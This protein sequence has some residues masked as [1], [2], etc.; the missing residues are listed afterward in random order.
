[1]GRLVDVRDGPVNV[2]QSYDGFRLV[3][4]FSI[5]RVDA[6]LVRPDLTNRGVFDDGW[7]ATQAFW[8]LWATLTVPRLLGGAYYLGHDRQQAAYEQGMGHELRHTIGAR[9][10][11]QAAPPLYLEVEGAYQLGRFLQGDI[12]A[13]MVVFLAVVRVPRL[14]LHPE[15]A[16]GVGA[17]SGD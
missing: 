11:V 10:G 6:F 13:W 8:G 14:A 2:R 16:L 9:V 7:D 12:S 3:S 1:S 17:A 15:V 5:L 4:R